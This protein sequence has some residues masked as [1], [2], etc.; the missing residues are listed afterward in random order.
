[1]CG[2][3]LPSRA[4]GLLQRNF[5]HISRRF[6]LP[7]RDLRQHLWYR[8]LSSHMLRNIRRLGITGEI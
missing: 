6:H 1:M 2:V 3:L 7:V 4:R 8:D 5:S